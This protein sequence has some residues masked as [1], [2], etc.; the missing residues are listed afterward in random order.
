MKRREEIIRKRLEQERKKKIEQ[1]LK[2]KLL[3]LH[4]ELDIHID[5][6]RKEFDLTE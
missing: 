6:V 5:D 4:K 3:T 1:I 2:N